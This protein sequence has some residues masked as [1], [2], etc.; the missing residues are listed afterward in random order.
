MRCPKWLKNC[1]FYEIYPQTYY[2]TNNDGIGDIQG[3][4]EK[5]DYVKNIGCDAIWLNPWYVS[6]FN[7][8]GYDITDYYN[9]APRY[10]T[11]DDAKRL[12]EEAH[13]RDMHIIIDLVPGHTSLECSWFKESQKVEKNEYSDRYIWSP[14]MMW[15]GDPELNRDE[16]YYVTGYSQ[17]GA[18]KTNFYYNQPALNYGYEKP[19]YEW[20]QPV[21]AEGPRATVE[22]I[23]N[24]MRFWLNMGCDGFRV[25]MASSLI[26]RD[27]NYKGIIR[28][29]K[30]FREMFDK[31]YPEAILVSEWGNP[32]I[33]IK[34]GFHC[35]F[36][37]D[38]GGPYTYDNLV[39][40]CWAWYMPGAN[41]FPPPV[42]SFEGQGDPKSFFTNYM[43][44]LK[45]TEKKGYI[46]MFSGN[47]DVHRLAKFLSP[48]EMKVFFAFL[49]TM[50]GVPFLYYGDEIG[51][52]YIDG[53]SK[54]GGSLR[55]GS[56]TPMQWNDWA[57]KGFSNANPEDLYLPVDNSENAPTVNAQYDDPNSILSKVR[58]LIAI[59]KKYVPLQANG[60]INPLYV[61]SNTYPFVYE[62]NSGKRKI[63]VVINPTKFNYEI[64]IPYKAKIISDISSMRVTAKRGRGCIKFKVKAVSY[65]IFQILDKETNYYVK[66]KNI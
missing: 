51:M 63:I 19:K 45:E 12:F 29:W 5:L 36:G 32:P 6:P 31:E 39:R 57:N 15:K 56:R 66:K 58:E 48:D 59:R 22:E 1:V 33:A 24:I 10:G 35:D 2:D 17:R 34:A 23:K 40:D 50:P 54:E 49:F 42:F 16:D 60:G 44:H 30:E 25:D 62:R 64:E 28:L 46:S 14:Y 13:R 37:L 8:A 55:T 20:E 4:I 61:K 26:K 65:G 9:V 7:D 3:I 21:D 41:K 43:N 38:A 11:N 47:H 18:Y 52:N 27:K 53:L